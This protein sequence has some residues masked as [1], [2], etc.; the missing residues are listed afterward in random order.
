M[1]DG[2]NAGDDQEKSIKELTSNLA[3]LQK[4]HDKLV[5][6]HRELKNSSG[7]AVALQKQ[8]DTSIADKSRLMRENSDLQTSFNEYKAGI[9]KQETTQHLTTAL[10][11]A[12]ARNASTAMKL[13]DWNLIKHDE[14]GKVIATSIAD[15]VNAIK[16]SDSVLFK[17]EGEAGPNGQNS[18][19]SID[20][21]PI[22]AAKRAADRLTTSGYETELAA[23]VASGKQS[24]IDA[25]FTKHHGIV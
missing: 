19:T 15:A 3:A 10:E 7:D 17:E 8:L 22:P 21:L 4:K 24:E 5:E 2:T 11:E 6:D 1:A 23:A 25:V 16:V 20:G 9:Q 13:V 18:K 14:T 12:G